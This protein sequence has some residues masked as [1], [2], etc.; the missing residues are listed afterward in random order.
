MDKRSRMWSRAIVFAG[1]NLHDILMLDTAHEGEALAARAVF[2]REVEQQ[3][4]RPRRRS[5]GSPR[6]A[7]LA[8][9]FLGW[10]VPTLLPR[11]CWYRGGR[12][13]VIEMRRHFPQGR[14]RPIVRVARIQDHGF[15]DRVN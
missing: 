5:G 3:G 15:L 13:R 6:A 8:S 10:T 9:L 2:L 12:W 11:E 14:I 1:L 7:S 4:R